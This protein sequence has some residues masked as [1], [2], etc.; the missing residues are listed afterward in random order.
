MRDV[1]RDVVAQVAPEELPLVEALARFD[2][3][4]VVR[5]LARRGG[6]RE[7]LGFGLGEIAA[8]VAPVVWLVVDEAARQLAGAVASRAATGTRTVMRR[9]LR[10]PAAPVTVPELTREQLA[11]I[12][13][14][15][16]ESAVQRGLGDKRATAIA[17]AVV[18]R[19]ALTAPGAPGAPGAPAQGTQEP[20][21]SGSTAG[22]GTPAQG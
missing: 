10:R 7:P 1:V 11:E 17:D 2:D 18:T 5:R 14:R 22:S 16:V 13:R 4:S 15:V 12:H 19:L 21:G 8:M 6:R 9:V 3:A 20:P